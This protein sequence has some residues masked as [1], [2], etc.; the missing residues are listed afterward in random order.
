[1]LTLC[2]VAQ[3]T[4]RTSNSVIVVVSHSTCFNVK[5]HFCFVRIVE[6]L[7]WK[8]WNIFVQLFSFP[9]LFFSSAFFSN[10]FFMFSNIK[11]AQRSD[12]TGAQ[13][14]IMRI[15]RIRLAMWETEI[16]QTL[17]ELHTF[18][19]FVGSQ[20]V[21]FIC[22]L[23][24]VFFANS[25]HAEYFIGYKTYLLIL[26]FVCICAR[27]ERIDTAEYLTIIQIDGDWIQ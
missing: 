3:S 12:W 8:S 5:R 27:E 17:H 24:S 1:M 10:N 11:R 26:R 25:F 23:L 9:N 18:G 6:E 14:K 19:S 13:C 22:S 4:K 21:N 15:V 20:F 7:K 2:L 16:K